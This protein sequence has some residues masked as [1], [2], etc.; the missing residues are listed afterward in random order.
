MHTIDL[1][2]GQGTPAKTTLGSAAIVVVIV[3][4]PILAASVMAD[5]YVWCRFLQ[6]G[7][8]NFSI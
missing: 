8:L 1:L 2:R 7:N 3:V 6:G 4:V 5:R